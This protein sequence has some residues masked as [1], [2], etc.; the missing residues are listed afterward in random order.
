MRLYLRLAMLNT[1]VGWLWV[2]LVLPLL[3]Y[4]LHVGGH[5]TAAKMFG[6]SWLLAV[7]V[8]LQGVPYRRRELARGRAVLHQLQELTAI[9]ASRPVS[10][11]DLKASLET[12]SARGVELDNG[13]CE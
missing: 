3:C 2:C 5:E 12:A 4:F 10:A 1:V 8:H 13:E 7:V 6:S 9:T 11:G